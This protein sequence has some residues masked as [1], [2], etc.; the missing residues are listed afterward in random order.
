[1]IGIALLGAVH[2]GRPQS[3]GRA[4]SSVDILRTR[5]RE[6]FRCGIHTFWC[7]K[8]DFSKL[9]C[10]ETDKGRGGVSQCGHFADKG[11]EGQFFAILCVRSLWMAP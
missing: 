9:R 10:V 8:S 5:W 7:K 1:M 11:G 2:K 6:H 3:R 4:L